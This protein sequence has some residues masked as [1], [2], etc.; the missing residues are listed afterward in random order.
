M[1]HMSETPQ[2]KCLLDIL[3]VYGSDPTK[4]EHG[5]LSTLTVEQK[6]KMIKAIDWA[7]LTGAVRQRAAA[8]F[9]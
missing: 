2:D 1:S 7:L 9:D 3:A 4:Y 5:Y 6:D 8:L